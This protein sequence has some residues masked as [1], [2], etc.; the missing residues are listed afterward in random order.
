MDSNDKIE[1]IKNL[2]SSL[3][4]SFTLAANSAAMLSTFLS[5][6]QETGKDEWLIMFEQSIKNLNV[7]M[8]RIVALS[9]LGSLKRENA[10]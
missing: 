2:Y 3:S 9:E 6:Y 10:N 4:E 7:H 8:E 5:C 1:S